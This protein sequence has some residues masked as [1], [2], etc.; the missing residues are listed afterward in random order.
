MSLLGRS[1]NKI[2]EEPAVAR[3]GPVLSIALRVVY[4]PSQLFRYRTK[5][6]ENVYNRLQRHR[7]MAASFR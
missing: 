5:L 1:A 6:Y 2:R 4:G 3:F 7:L